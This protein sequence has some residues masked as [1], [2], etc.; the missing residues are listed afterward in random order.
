MKDFCKL[1]VPDWFSPISLNSL[2]NAALEITAQGKSGDIWVDLKNKR[3]AA[4]DLVTPTVIP[5]S[6]PTAPLLPTY[7]EQAKLALLDSQISSAAYFELLKFMSLLVQQ[8]SDDPK[9]I[10]QNIEN[11]IKICKAKFTKHLIEQDIQDFS[12]L[13]LIPGGKT[14]D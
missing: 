5:P 4:F 12:H 3:S 9:E 13:T 8:N 2:K 14:N 10:L 1:N 6:S 11:K 7:K